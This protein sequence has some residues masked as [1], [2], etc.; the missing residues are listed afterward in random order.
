[1][2]EQY[3]EVGKITNTHGIMGEVRVQPWAD[4]PEFLCQFKTLYVDQA[5]WP[6]KVERARVHKNMVILKLEGVTDVP[7]A[8]SM[9][10]AILYIDRKDAALPE[11][12]F[13]L[14]DLMGL[15]VRDA[16][17]GK[18]LGKIA[19]IMNLPANNVYVVRGG[20]REILV[21]AVPQFIAETN[22]EGGY[23]RV[24]MMEGL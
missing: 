19:D 24:N 17:S 15:E 16:Q 1:M 13:F 12:S 5:H 2:P 4:S 11:G 8:L 9:R 3:L 10:N 14:A 6:I 23:L 18:V 21:P 7:S 20:E 22:V